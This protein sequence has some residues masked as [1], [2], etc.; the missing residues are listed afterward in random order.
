LVLVGWSAAV[1]LGQRPILTPAKWRDRVDPQGEASVA[2]DLS[3]AAKSMLD[4]LKPRPEE[5]IIRHLERASVATD[6]WKLLDDFDGLI[7]AL[8]GARQFRELAMPAR[9]RA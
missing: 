2:S 3:C 5:G 4:L 8:W 7:D 1:E 6:A 9:Q